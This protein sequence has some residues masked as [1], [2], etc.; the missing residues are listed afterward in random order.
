MTFYF[1]VFLQNNLFALGV[2]GGEKH[3]YLTRQERMFLIRTTLR[4][5]LALKLN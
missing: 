2:L 3:L 5:S 4:R 1:A